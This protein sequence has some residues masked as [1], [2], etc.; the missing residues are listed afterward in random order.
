MKYF[1][2]IFLGIISISCNKFYNSV[3]ESIHDNE[4]NCIFFTPDSEFDI[5]RIKY[6]TQNDEGTDISMIIKFDEFNKILRPDDTVYLNIFEDFSY[7]FY[8]QSAV[9][10][11]FKADTLVYQEK[12]IIINEES[13]PL[14][15]CFDF[16]KIHRDYTFVREDGRESNFE[17]TFACDDIH[18]EYNTVTA[19]GDSMAFYLIFDIY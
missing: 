16:Y 10:G 6:Y 11:V 1:L 19:K 17:K 14:Q 13:E 7:E 15:E 9:P 4:D 12:G 3:C 8:V 2:L 18:V 5:D